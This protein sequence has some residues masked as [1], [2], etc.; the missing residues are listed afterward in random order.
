MPDVS[1]LSQRQVRGQRHEKGTQQVPLC[2][3]AVCVSVCIDVMCVGGRK[4]E[5][6]E[7]AWT[8]VTEMFDLNDDSRWNDDSRCFCLFIVKLQKAPAVRPAPK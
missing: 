2:F 1:H 5:A 4:G 8:W 6:R 7:R 3:L